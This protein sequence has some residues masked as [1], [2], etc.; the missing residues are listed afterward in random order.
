MD[1]TSQRQCDTLEIEKKSRRKNLFNLKA[2]YGAST[3]SLGIHYVIKLKPGWLNP[4]DIFFEITSS[5]SKGIL[6]N[7]QIAS[8]S[9]KHV[10]S[11]YNTAV[12]SDEVRDSKVK[13]CAFFE[14][15]RQSQ[16]NIAIL[17]VNQP[18]SWLRKSNRKIT[19]FEMFSKLSSPLVAR[20]QGGKF[21]P[22]PAEL[23]CTLRDYCFW[24][25][26]TR[27]WLAAQ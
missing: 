10:F 12:R 16:T 8:H 25:S 11:I 18:R 22:L 27:V 6:F 15:H 7:L 4:L 26:Y 17:K 5:L 9:S 24:A 20:K 23:C 1:Q 13:C 3:T 19:F 2:C 14:E 21:F